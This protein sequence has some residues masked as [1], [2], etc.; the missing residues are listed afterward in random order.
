MQFEH[1]APDGTLLMTLA[2][3][4]R[5]RIRITLAAAAIA[6]GLAVPAQASAACAHAGDNPNNLT[7]ADTKAATICLLNDIRR[8]NGLRPFRL[9]G[10]LSLASQR[11]TNSMTARKYF[12]HGDFVGR[13]RATRY[14]S[15]TRGWTVGENIAWGSW[16]YASPAAIVK[17]WMNSPP[18][19]ANILNRSFR[20]IGIGVSRGA[21][22]GGQDKAATYATDFGT[23]F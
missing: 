7:L 5:S 8:G 9:N 1:A 13:I 10:R 3:S 19:R 22:V 15:H 21:P 4:R 14:L 12:A 2:T 6:A 17:G 20:E 18:H 16:D 11:H 23:R